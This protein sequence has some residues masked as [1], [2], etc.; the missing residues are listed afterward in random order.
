MPP[1]TEYL[2]LEHL[3]FLQPYIIL[4]L[5]RDSIPLMF[6]S[7]HVNLLPVGVLS[8]GKGWFIKY[9]G[10][11]EHSASDWQSIRLGLEASGSGL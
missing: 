5:K 11:L 4:G 1:I 7:P 8:L 9:L 2:K 10:P 6:T 3:G